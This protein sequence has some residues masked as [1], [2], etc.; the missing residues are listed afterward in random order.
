[1]TQVCFLPLLLP[2]QAFDFHEHLAC[3]RAGGPVAI[4]RG[5]TNLDG[6]NSV[7]LGC[8]RGSFAGTSLGYDSTLTR[9]GNYRGPISSRRT[10]CSLAQASR[11]RRSFPCRGMVVAQELVPSGLRLRAVSTGPTSVSRRVAL[12]SS[13]ALTAVA[14]L[15]LQT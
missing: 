15:V 9:F 14:A 4:H 12:V 11:D 8:R 3:Y 10:R 13:S 7:E 1:M 6:D 2:S 5:R